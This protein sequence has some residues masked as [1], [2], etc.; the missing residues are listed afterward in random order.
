[1]RKVLVGDFGAMLRAG[2]DDILGKTDLTVMSTPDDAVMDELVHAMPAVVILDL[3]RPGT[4]ELI[5]EITRD[6]PA[7]QVVACSTVE[8]LMRVYPPFHRGEFYESEL[9]EG[10]LTTVVQA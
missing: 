3:D 8:P 5:Q 10:T 2:F 4:A 9:E 6:F 1:M 7:V